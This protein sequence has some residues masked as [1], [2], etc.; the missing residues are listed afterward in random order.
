MPGADRGVPSPT[1]LHDVLAEAREAG[2]LGPGPITPQI[3]HAEGF[4]LVARRLAAPG[5]TRPRL[6][7]L[8]SGGG[9]PGLV[10]ALQWPE[11]SVESSRRRG[12]G[13]PSWS[14][15]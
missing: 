12:G 7:D 2:F 6:V 11:A 8:G 13:Q 10:V 15:R 3:R 4:A 1:L 9:L 14:G 5:P